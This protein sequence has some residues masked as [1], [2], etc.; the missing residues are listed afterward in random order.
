MLRRGEA[1][2][3]DHLLR[4]A[5]SLPPDVLFKMVLLACVCTSM[6]DDDALNIYDGGKAEPLYYICSLYTRVIYVD[7]DG[8]Y[9]GYIEAAA[10]FVL[11]CC[12][13]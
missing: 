11:G 9:I 6:D 4:R 10:V 12:Y 5:S 3:L 7:D 1:R 2:R 8:L 13:A